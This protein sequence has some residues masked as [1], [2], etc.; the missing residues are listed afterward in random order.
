MGITINGISVKTNRID[1]STGEI[2]NPPALDYFPSVFNANSIS[3][4]TT[5]SNQ[6]GFNITANNSIDGASAFVAKTVTNSTWEVVARMRIM[7][8][9][10]TWAVPI[11][12]SGIILYNSN[13]SK[14]I[15]FGTGAHSIGTTVIQNNY[16]IGNKQG[17]DSEY[18]PHFSYYSGSGGNHTASVAEWF[19]VSFDGARYSFYDSLEGFNWR[20]LYIEL[21]SSYLGN[22]THA[23]AGFFQRFT[24]TPEQSSPTNGG[25]NL[26]RPAAYHQGITIPY[27]YDNA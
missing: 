2:F 27:W 6:Y 16:P 4:N 13:N 11:Q 8:P 7:Q 24:T 12:S 19:K 21:S 25:Y 23:G 1:P 17:V 15:M 3:L 5:Y 22:I 10:W 20:L 26:N 14:T 18:S 9:D